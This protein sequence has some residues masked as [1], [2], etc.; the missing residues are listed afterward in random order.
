[1]HAALKVLVDRKLSALESASAVLTHVAQKLCAQRFS[2][3]R[4][5]LVTRHNT[6]LNQ[7]VAAIFSDSYLIT[8]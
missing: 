8:I 1:M 2:R 3:G 5:A 6:R 7:A 4:L